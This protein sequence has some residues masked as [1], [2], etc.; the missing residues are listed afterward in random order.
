MRKNKLIKRSKKLI[1][2]G[3]IKKAADAAFFYVKKTP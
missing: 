2:E 1:S 3:K